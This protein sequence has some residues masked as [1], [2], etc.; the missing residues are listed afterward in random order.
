MESSTFGNVKSNPDAAVR[1]AMQRAQNQDGLPEIVIGVIFLIVACVLWVPEVFPRRGWIGPL[2]LILV[3][4]VIGASPWIVRKLRRRYL[5]EQAGYVEFKP[6]NRKRIAIICG[7]ALV[8]AAVT[9][10]YVAKGALPPASWTVAG[11]GILGGLLGAYAGRTSRF[12]HRW[13]DPGNGWDCCWIE[14]SLTW[15]GAGD[16]VWRHGGAFSYFRHHCA[17][18]LHSPTGSDR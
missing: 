10:F 4:P 11:T 14:R 3:S 5:I 15:D 8:I 13:R 1:R 7:L 6:V 2:G 18:R 9:A 16:S 17:V 12:C